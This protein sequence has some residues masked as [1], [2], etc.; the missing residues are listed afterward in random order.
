LK[1]YAIS[2]SNRKNGNSIKLLNKSLE[3]IKDTVGENGNEFNLI[4]LYKLN[5]TGCRS[6]FHCKKLDSKYYGKC[7]INDDLKR[8]L[9]DI[10]TCDGLILA[11]PVYF[12]SVTGQMRCFYERLTFPYF[13]YLRD[14]DSLAPK[15]FP[16]ATIYSMNLKKDS[17]LSNIY[18]STF[19][20]FDWVLNTVFD[21]VE[22]LIVY[23]TYQ[24]NDYSKYAID[25]FD[26]KEKR[27]TLENQFPKD[28]ESSYNLGVNLAKK[29][30][31]INKV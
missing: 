25:V 13:T 30:L 17:E 18:N 1:F 31:K 4:N 20:H 22:R 3:G 7:P 19:D 8:L 14:V 29:S 15:K 9:E 6:C 2:G 26:E 11:S 28:L 5:F 24:F 10:S 23:D 27:K 16:I 21:S 12:S